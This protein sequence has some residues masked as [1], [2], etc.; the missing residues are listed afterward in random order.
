MRGNE[1]MKKI[2]AAVIAAAMLAAAFAGCGE[3]KTD[4]QTGA[5]TGSGSVTDSGAGAGSV[6]DSGAC[7]DSGMETDSGA[8]TDSGMETGSGAETDSG[9]VTDSGMVT[10]SGEE[11]GSGVV[12]DSGTVT[13]AV[14]GEHVHSWGG[15]RVARAATCG[16]AGSR[17]RECSV[18]GTSE[19]ESVPATGKHSWG[20]W[21]VARAATCGA[22]GSRIRECS[23][24]GASESESVPATGKHSWG[25][26]RVAR[27][28]T[29]GAAGS[30]IRECSVC[31]A[32]ESESVPATGKHSWGGWRVAR[33]ATCGTVGSRIRECSVCGASESESVPATGKHNWGNWR[34]DSLP[35]LNS[36]G[37]QVRSCSVCGAREERGVPSLSLEWDGDT[38]AWMARLPDY[39][40]LSDITLP[41]THDSGAVNSF[42]GIG[43]CQ[44]LSPRSQFDAGARFLDVR[45]KLVDGKLSVYHGILD[46]G[47]TFDDFVS[48]CSGF[49][50]AH[51]GEVIVMSIKEEDADDPGFAGAVNSV[52]DGGGSLWFTE[53]RLPT[54]GEAR[55][56]IVL[57]SRCSKLGRGLPFGNGWQDNAVFS[58]N[59]GV[60]ARIQDHYSVVDASGIET[61]WREISSL[62]D[63]ARSHAGTLCV[64]FTS[65][66]TG[67]FGIVEVADAI[68]PRLTK[69]AASLGSPAGVGIFACDFF[70]PDLGRALAGINFA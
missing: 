42:F 54:L 56:K 18:C 53:N 25:V 61:K 21:R 55:G 39:L 67:A 57:F 43:Q 69:L 27:A 20:V 15:W 64:N 63:F 7:A 49:L 4:A 8:G 50:A 13:D 45:L 58:V 38:S 44:T 37:K 59:N 22:A 3:N 1:L 24:C 68:N 40:S 46:M 19:S 16:A 30:R 6:T 23:V 33:T 10:D 32:S 9:S 41:G 12:T 2:L 31:G 60:A 47:L 52:I 35:T 66:Y 17:I 36:D 34:D 28:A 70:T 65:G 29:C 5:V 62:V 48:A 14:T 26:W 11:T 51:P